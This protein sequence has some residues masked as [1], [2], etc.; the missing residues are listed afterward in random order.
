MVAE[1][2]QAEVK[3]MKA[4]SSSPFTE[5]QSRIKKVFVEGSGIDPVFTNILNFHS[6]IEISAGM[7]A[8]TPIHEGMGWDASKIKRFRH[9]VTE[10]TYVTLLE[11]EDGSVW[12]GIIADDSDRG[13][14]Y[15]APSKAGDKPYLPPIPDKI[16]LA[17]SKRYQVEVP[18]DDS[19][20]DWLRENKQI[21]I[22]FTEGAKKSLSLLS[23]GFVAISLYG[24]SCGVLKN[25]SGN[26]VKDA[27]QPYVENR[28]CLVAFDRDS[29]P[30]TREKVHQHTHK[31][32]TALSNSGAFTGCLQWP[33]SWGKGLDDVIV[34]GHFAGLEKKI[35]KLTLEV[36]E[37]NGVALRH[38]VGETFA[39]QSFKALY[40]YG[41]EWIC[42][43]DNL[44]KW[45]KNHYKLIEDDTEIARIS[46][47]CNDFEKTIIKKDGSSLTLYPYASPK[48]VSEA[49]NWAKSRL[50]TTKWDSSGLIN[51]TNGVVKLNWTNN[52]V[53]WEL[54]PHDSTKHFFLT[55]PKIPYLPDAFTGDCDRL[56][57][58]L[59]PAHREIFLKT[60]AAAFDLKN[61]R[62]IRGRNIKALLLKGTG[63]NGKDALRTAVSVIFRDVI[64]LSFSDFQSYDQGRK[65]PVAALRD[66]RMSWCSENNNDVAL[67]KL[68]ALKCAIT[69]S[70]LVS[71][72]KNKTGIEFTPLA[73]LLFNIN[74]IPY[75]NGSS[76]AIQTRFAIIQFLKSFK[77]HPK[78]G[79][80]QADPRFAYDPDFLQNNVCPALFIKL[81]HALKD[82]IK[83]G[84]DFKAVDDTYS[85]I[86]DSNSHL[87]SFMRDVGLSE[88]EG[89]C[90]VM[91]IWEKLEQWYEDNEFYT[92]VGDRK[93]WIDPRPGD[94]C[95][96]AAN[97]V[98]AK[99]MKFLP[100]VKL[101]QRRLPNGKTRPVFV[102]VCFNSKV[103]NNRNN[104][105]ST[106]I[107][108]QS[109]PQQILTGSD[110]NPNQGILPS[111][112][113][114]IKKSQ[115]LND[116]AIS[117]HE[118]NNFSL[119]TELIKKIG[120][121]GVVGVEENL[122][123]LYNSTS[124]D[125]AEAVF[126]GELGLIGDGCEP[127]KPTPQYQVGDKVRCYPTY[128]HAQKD[129]KITAKITNIEYEQGYLLTCSISYKG[130][131]GITITATICG[132]NS[133]WILG[134]A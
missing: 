57:E 22:T 65:F 21:P 3:A 75:I 70:S 112:G 37:K 25:P 101:E 36:A 78:P 40:G 18:F 4:A 15:Q 26:I 54:I 16:R 39:Q 14:R 127:L 83:D 73:V 93:E 47:W 100:K 76:D 134:K 35:Q 11:N 126:G 89:E 9:Q 90:F 85:E 120:V 55:E 130:K 114:K 108:P 105:N 88:G 98:A 111:D 12:Q 122:Q 106:P 41:D 56:L 132:G 30:K 124:S 61:V 63:A 97:Q 74:D 51:C 81:L 45:D 24:C 43:S 10:D 5:F 95:I 68:Q 28:I 67:D 102:G 8:E 79:E 86:Q 116:E 29:K 52:D 46:N 94:K 104:P 82:L 7:D 107:Q 23:Q 125:N 31:L 133:D 34:K 131:K 32:I 58:C 121:V 87:F 71:E 123:P 84:I 13:Y 119:E 117:P 115:I 77:T 53:N 38:N 60:I 50:K 113:E 91:D 99:L 128:E 129:W 59:E 96:R 48:Y 72:L 66:T 80:L 33:L 118:K 6:D 17:I 92:Y 20:W 110:F 1:F 44:Y 27:L 49:L 69:G 62:R 64:S 2:I 109:Q 19:F 42:V 103:V